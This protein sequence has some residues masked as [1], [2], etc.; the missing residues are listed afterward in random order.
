MSWWSV[1]VVQVVAILS[2]VV[3]VERLVCS[4]IKAG[5]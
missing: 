4:A 3:A 1:V 2:V 5:R